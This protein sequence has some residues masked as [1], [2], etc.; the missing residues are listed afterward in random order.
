MS[1][2]T[3]TGS[4]NLYDP[5]LAQRAKYWEAVQKDLAARNVTPYSKVTMPAP[6]QTPQ[7]KKPAK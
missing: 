4:G 5:R 3:S 7:I 6:K 2:I 1:D